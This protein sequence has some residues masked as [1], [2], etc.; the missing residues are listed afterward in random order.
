MANNKTYN[1]LLGTCYDAEILGKLETV[2]SKSG[3]IKELIRK[4]I[5]GGLKGVQ[6]FTEDAEQIAREYS[7]IIEEKFPEQFDNNNE[8][9][10]SFVVNIDK[11]GDIIDKISSIENNSDYIRQLILIDMGLIDVAGNRYMLLDADGNE[12][13]KERTVSGRRKR[14]QQ[15]GIEKLTDEEKEDKK[16]A[17]REAQKRYMEKKGYDEYKE[18]Y[19]NRTLSLK[20][21]EDEKINNYCKLNNIQRNTLIRK[22]VIEYIENN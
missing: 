8:K 15:K 21:D 18:K 13:K 7:N 14:N 6:E 10:M 3:Y 9:I 17:H 5:T 1:I 22:I 16:V 11:D 20:K 4:D 2:K 19:I 12:R